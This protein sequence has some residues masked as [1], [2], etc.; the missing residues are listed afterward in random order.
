MSNLNNN[1]PGQPVTYS[2]REFVRLAKSLENE[3][4]EFLRFVLTGD[5]KGQHQATLDH[6]RNVL[7]NDHQVDVARDY[8]SVIGITDGIVVDCALS[9]YPVPNPAEALTS[10]IHITHPF[11]SGD[12]S[13]FMYILFWPDWIFVDD[14]SCTNP[15]NPKFSVCV[16]GPTPSDPYFF[17]LPCLSVRGTYRGAPVSRRKE[18]ILRTWPPPRC[19][20][21][22]STRC[23]RL[24]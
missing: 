3:N 6:V 21:F 20:D 16:L 12:V 18:A 7:T 13:R 4:P 14:P 8:D 15:P 5:A 11:T 10:S 22:T 23:L 19:Q 24:A 2:L 17:P 9:V 1:F